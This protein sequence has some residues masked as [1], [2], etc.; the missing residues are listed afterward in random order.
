[1]AYLQNY[2]R[3]LIAGKLTPTTISKIRKGN[4]ISF[5][6]PITKRNESYTGKGSIQR[7]VFVFVNRI[8]DLPIQILKF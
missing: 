3:K 6:Y 4:I 1:M 8:Q 2:Q 7:L 5:N